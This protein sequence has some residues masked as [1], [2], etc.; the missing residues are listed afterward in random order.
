MTIFEYL[1]KGYQSRVG[2]GYLLAKF[3]IRASQEIKRNIPQY[4]L[5]DVSGKYLVF[6][7]ETMNHHSGD[8]GETIEYLKR[9][10]RANSVI[11][12]RNVNVDVGIERLINI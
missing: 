1:T 8:L 9:I 2:L 11:N 7:P 10:K 3:C 5:F 12:I 6:N 4:Y